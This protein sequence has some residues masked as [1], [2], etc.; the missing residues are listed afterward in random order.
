MAE[1]ESALNLSAAETKPA[2][3]SLLLFALSLIVFLI[4]VDYTAVNLALPTMADD[5]HTSLNTIQW[6]LTAYVLT[7]A[8]LIFPC[9]GLSAKFTTKQLCIT[10]LSLF[11]VA[12]ALATFAFSSHMLIAA[13]ILQG[14]SAAIYGPAVYGLIH[15]YVPEQ[16]RG[17]AMGILSLGV[18]LGLAVGPFIGGS[19]LTLWSWRAIFLINLPIGLAALY[20]IFKQQDTQQPSTTSLS[21][22]KSS[23]FLI[24]F[25]TLSLIYIVNQYQ[26]WQQHA[27][28]YIGW[29]IL[30]IVALISFVFLQQKIANPLIPLSLFK[31]RKYA[32]CCV[33]IFFEQAGFSIIVVATSLYLQNT[34]HYSPLISSLIFL[35]LTVIFGVIALI[36]GRWVDQQGLVLPTISGMLLMAAGSLL[37]A[38]VAVSSYSLLVCPILF[39]LG[40]GMGL[41]FIGLNS[42]VV[43]TVSQ[44]HIGIATSVF[45]VL[46]LIANSFAIT[47]TTL[48]YQHANIASKFNGISQVMLLNTVLSLLAVWFFWRLSAKKA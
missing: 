46:A 36:G 40:V 45:M 21:L 8:L 16:A 12:S 34:L 2:A 28:L 1:Q 14:L 27:G 41:A 33:G 10:G 43:K 22:S 6:V 30:A 47:F 42:G 5:L 26:A 7:W 44:G 23:I 35:F 18:G 48:F 32:A 25:A 9:G 29:A 17:R 31:N 19:L 11:I 4:N 3:F 39:V 37:F 15:C 20:V 24:G 13:R 38:G